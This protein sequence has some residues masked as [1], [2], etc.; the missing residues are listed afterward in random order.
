M[1]KTRNSITH[2]RN[3]KLIKCTQRWKR[4]IMWIYVTT[5]GVEQKVGQGKGKYYAL[6]K[7]NTLK[8]DH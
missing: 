2:A 5:G 8:R 4:S 3:S 6:F 7:R 1:P